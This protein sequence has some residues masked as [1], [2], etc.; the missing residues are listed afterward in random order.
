MLSTC[1]TATSSANRFQFKFLQG[2]MIPSG[3][4]NDFSESD[5]SVFVPPLKK[6]QKIPD[7]FFTER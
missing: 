1:K 7:N 6:V 3:N 5:A 4:I 2:T